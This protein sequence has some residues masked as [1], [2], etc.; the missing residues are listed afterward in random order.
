MKNYTVVFISNVWLN[1]DDP[2]D[3]KEWKTV[4]AKSKQDAIDTL[5]GK[6]MVISCSE[7]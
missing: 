1:E 5:K 6:A 4:T 7:D 2:S 3:H